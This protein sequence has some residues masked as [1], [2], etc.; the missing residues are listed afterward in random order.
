MTITK[1]IIIATMAISIAAC[2][3]IDPKYQEFPS[4]QNSDGDNYAT[5]I[6]PSTPKEAI[7]YALY[8]YGNKSKISKENLA[9]SQNYQLLTKHNYKKLIESKQHSYYLYSTSSLDEK[10][11][12]NKNIEADLLR[13]VLSKYPKYA[14][15]SSYNPN[16]LIYLTTMYPNQ[17]RQVFKIPADQ[18]FLLTAVNNKSNDNSEIAECS[19]LIYLKAK[20]TYQVSYQQGTARVVMIFPGPSFTFC[21]LTINLD[22]K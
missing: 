18:L 3:S 12:I 10:P 2:S 8:Q 13:S 4:Y 6:I 5:L 17:D 7:S 20:E 21:N 22:T 16:R 19:K 15:Q 11:I 14:F 1:K 9:I